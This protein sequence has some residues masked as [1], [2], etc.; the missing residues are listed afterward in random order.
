MSDKGIM[1][2]LRVDTARIT[3]LAPLGEE[4]HIAGPEGAAVILAPPA[5]EFGDLA[6]EARRELCKRTG[7]ELPILDEADFAGIEAL[8]HNVIAIGHAANNQL[9][10]RL[11]YL[12]RLSDRDY[13]SDGLRLV[14]VHDPLGDGHN[15]LAALG[16]TPAVAGRSL[17][18]L[19]D[20]LVERDGGYLTDRRL[21]ETDP[22][23]E[24]PDPDEL[25]A[26]AA[27]A[28]SSAY[29][30]R[31]GAFLTALDHLSA[32]GEER[33][34]RAF[35]ELI[36][37]YATGEIPLSFWLMS[38]VDFW[39][40]RLVIG[41]DDVEEFPY[42]SDEERLL[43]A[44]FI[45]SCT[46]YCHDS[47]T[48]QKWRITEEEHQV[49]NHHTFPAKGLYFGCMYLRRHGYEVVDIDAWLDN[50]LRVFARAAEAGRSFDEGGAGYS[51]LVG[52]H[53]LEVAL[54]RGDSSYLSSEKMVRYA[55][56]AVV[57]QNSRS[58]LVP[59][60]DCH[61]YHTPASSAA[62]VL[63]R[64]AEWHNHQGYK[65]VAQRAA[66][67]AA[68][69]DV[70]ARGVT[71]SEPEEHLGLFVLPLDPVIHR[72]TGLPRFPG[73]P[74]P[75]SPPNV[76]V[77][78]CFDKL[79][80][81]GGWDED[82]DYLL[83]QGFG[84]GQHGHP[85]ANAISQYQVR[86]RVFLV[87][88]DYIRRMP[89]QHNMVMV[90][91]DGQH[92]PIPVTARLESALQ[93]GW[94][95][96]TRTTLPE[97]NGCD[98]TRALL[99]INADCVLVVD[100]LTARVAGEYE[101]RCYWRTLGDVRA[102]PRGMIA[103]HDGELFHVIELTDS[104]RRLDTEAAPLNGTEYPKYDFG[105]GVPRVLRETR[106]MRLERGEE[107]CFVNLLLP[108]G[109]SEAARR[110]IKWAEPGHII[111]AG[112]GPVITMNEVGFQIEHEGSHAFEEARR[113]SALCAD[114]QPAAA[115]A[116]R[117]SGRRATPK[118][119]VALPSPATC[120][121]D[122]GGPGA[123]VGCEDGSILSLTA[124]G[125]LRLL[126]KAGDRIGAIL[127][128]HVFGEAEATCM[129]ASYDEKLRFFSPDGAPRMTVDL[130]RNG[131]MPAWGWAL[132][133]ADLDGDGRLW[134]IVGTAAWRVHAV[135]PDGSFR[136]TFETA[137]HSV[138]CLAAGDLNADG[139]DEVAV[140]TVYFCVPAIDGDGGRL[141]E[142]ED[143]NDYWTA[144]PHFP[145]IQ[146]SDVDGDGHLEVV[147]AAS[148][149]LVHCISHLGEKKW[150][151]SIGD[152]PAGLVVMP[153]GIAA[154]SRTGDL[155]CIDG[156][157]VLLWRIS[158]DSPCTALAGHGQCV[159]V[160][161][162]AGGLHLVR[163]DGSVVMSA[164]IGSEVQHIMSLPDNQLVA[165]A[166][167]ELVAFS[168]P[169]NA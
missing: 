67:E 60:G 107:T 46:E 77:G 78:E 146:V 119:R 96:F 35:I 54:A 62:S 151:L 105:E 166:A 86:G 158:L 36:S 99:W 15:V 128:G 110:D 82:D 160:A 79:S 106:K 139:R 7:A 1:I 80:L 37:P 47:I 149:T 130:P 16:Y 104:D 69:A 134:P 56:L 163:S 152:D 94:G 97:Y 155:H 27:R 70:L 41:W 22:A 55:D 17:G 85:D 13:R 52:N 31:P 43:V 44:N 138:T 42:F 74:P 28:S 49:F 109:A 88:A 2:Q 58:H 48:Y 167:G 111:I 64:A 122:T 73:Y 24:T 71:A 116:V 124:S 93:F 81:R 21:L 32:A 135:A 118:W 84:D 30:G 3:Q 147:T 153:W 164:D 89:K 141:W 4:T 132:C 140:G 6:Q 131:H 169:P 29:H 75:P 159:A 57:I 50:S 162:E 120:L 10:R 33:W 136:W 38:A 72:W 144:G 113:V 145:F 112:R 126:E 148:D 143:Y 108:N 11:H 121:A 59:F 129:V 90:I 14:S 98:W 125:D 53:L 165:A 5:P 142:D 114:S 68:E 87:D 61:G 76:P 115:P 34:A 102:T 137:A 100:S 83:L 39:T 150:T 157:G 103:D 156:N 18:R 154:A 23:P 45:V 20:C 51:W 65:W 40:D 19:M 123:L 95:A 26:S 8:D 117:V 63:L 91:R 66:P 133:L 161:T 92:A 168:E 9:L 127:S 12:R 101:L 25:L